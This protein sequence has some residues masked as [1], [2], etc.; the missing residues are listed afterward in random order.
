MPRE[1]TQSDRTKN[2]ALAR[3]SVLRCGDR[4]DGLAQHRRSSLVRTRDAAYP[5]IMPR[6]AG[7]M[8]RYYAY[9]PTSGYYAQVC[10]GWVNFSITKKWKCNF[11]DCKLSPGL[12]GF[13]LPWCICKLPSIRESV[14]STAEVNGEKGGYCRMTRRSKLP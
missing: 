2:P 4:G 14:T 13:K 3:S 9:M 6:S 12:L 1:P 7:L 5:G 8:P 10:W 11:G